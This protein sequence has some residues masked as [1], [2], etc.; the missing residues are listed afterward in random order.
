M[1]ATKNPNKA[2]LFKPH[3][4]AKVLPDGKSRRQYNADHGRTGSTV[5]VNGRNNTKAS[6]KAGSSDKPLRAGSKQPRAT[7]AAQA[8]IYS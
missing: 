2:P 3:H 1:S 4:A 5:G 8:Q 7:T 6:G